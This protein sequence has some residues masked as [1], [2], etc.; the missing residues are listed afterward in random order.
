MSLIWKYFSLSGRVAFC[1]SCKF[2]KNY[3][4]RSPTTFL[5]SH[6]CASHPE[7]YDDFLAKRKAKVPQQQTLKRAF[8]ESAPTTSQVSDDLD[9][10]T[11]QD[12]DLMDFDE[13]EKTKISEPDIAIALRAKS[14][15]DK[16]GDKR[17][18]INKFLMEMICVDLQPL[19]IVENIGFRR[20]V[21]ELQPRYK[22]PSRQFYPKLQ[23]AF[24]QHLVHQLKQKGCLV[25]QD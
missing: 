20:L 16:D 10:I 23:N 24:Y 8:A 1:K 2:S 9:V 14:P 15:W 3:P 6:L 7:L 5:I 18:M 12:I 11:D 4:P 17:N 25:V 13:T 21:N 22:I 19:S